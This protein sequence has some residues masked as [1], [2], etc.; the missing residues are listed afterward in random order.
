[1]EK[2]LSQN[3]EKYSD[4]LLITS[5]PV[6]FTARLL[7]LLK[8]IMVLTESKW[9]HDVTHLTHIPGPYK[10][11]TWNAPNPKQATPKRNTW[12]PANQ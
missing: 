11:V 5:S 4:P 3:I 12:I 9:Q 6:A 7:Q 8:Q 2:H 1:M 10:P